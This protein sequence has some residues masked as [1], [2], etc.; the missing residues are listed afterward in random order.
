MLEPFGSAVSCVKT[1]A[2][3]AATSGVVPSVSSPGGSGSGGSA[4]RRV[5][6]EPG[7]H[8]RLPPA[9]LQLDELLEAR[10]RGR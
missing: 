1:D 4:A 3:S 6:V 7:L 5:G 2:A 8:D 10:G 9:G